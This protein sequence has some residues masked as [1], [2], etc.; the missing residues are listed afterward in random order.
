LAN[1]GDSDLLCRDRVQRGLWTL[2]CCLAW[3]HAASAFAF[4]HHWSHDDAYW[5][6]ARE[7]AAVVGIDW[8]GGLYFNYLF[9]LLWTGD[10]AWWWTFPAAHRNRPRSYSLFLDAYLAFIAFNATVV[11]GHGTV[12]YFGVAATLG[13]VW[14]AWS[15]RRRGKSD[16]GRNQGTVQDGRTDDW[17]ER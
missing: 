15:S 9:I 4:Y 6:T 13:L 17:P 2:G 5:R 11:F 8:G 10:V 1:P 3:A 14:L 7:T 12:R 16:A